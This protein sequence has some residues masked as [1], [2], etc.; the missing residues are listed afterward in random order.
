MIRVG[1][2]TDEMRGVWLPPPF[3]DHSR[4]AALPHLR[5]DDRRS[6]HRRGRPRRFHSSLGLSGSLGLSARRGESERERRVAHRQRHQ[7]FVRSPS[8]I[9]I[10]G[11]TLAPL[12]RGFSLVA[13]LIPAPSS[14]RGPRLRPGKGS[15][16]ATNIAMRI[17]RRRKRVSR[18]TTVRRDR[19]RGAVSP[20]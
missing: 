20:V 10:D 8:S 14:S 3:H 17:C 18:G 11:P 5:H 4:H 12:P 1:Y 16:R 19:L 6:R 9:L 7:I 15:S 13:Q 2:G